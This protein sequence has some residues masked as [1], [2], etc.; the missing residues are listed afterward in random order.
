MVECWRDEFF[1]LR[2]MVDR[3]VGLLFLWILIGGSLHIA[4]RGTRPF[5]QVTFSQR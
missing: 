5:Q 4:H 3:G 2:R 1:G